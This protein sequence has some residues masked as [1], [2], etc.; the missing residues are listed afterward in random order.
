M[1]ESKIQSK[2]IKYLEKQWFIV[3]KMIR[4]NKSWIA[5]LLILLWNQKCI[6]C[7]VKQ[8]TWKQSKLQKYIQKQFEKTWQKRIT[9][10]WYDDFLEKFNL[11]INNNQL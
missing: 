3:I 8:E 4:T 11:L 1:L 7:E 9:A 6:W 2:I 10:L 5:D